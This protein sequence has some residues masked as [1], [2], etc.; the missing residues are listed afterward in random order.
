MDTK[1]LELLLETIQC[2]SM[3]RAAE[4]L[5]YT[6]SG[7]V[8]MLNSLE[9]ELSL[10]LLV[11]NYRGVS[12]T[13]NGK[14]L[15]PYIR[16]LVDSANRLEKQISVLIEQNRRVLYIGA[17]PAVARHLIPAISHKFMKSNPNVNIHIHVGMEELSEWVERE[18]IELAIC[19]HSITNNNEW[20]PV[21]KD[22]VYVAVPKEADFSLPSEQHTSVSLDELVDCPVLLTSHNPKSPGSGKLAQWV[23][24]SNRSQHLTIKAPDGSVQLSMVAKGLGITFLSSLYRYECPETVRMYPLDPPLY[25]NLG[26]IIK[27]KKFLSPLAKEFI[28]F[29]K[30]YLNGSEMIGK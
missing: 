6:Q 23:T 13:P 17:Y 22:E 12:F 5:N 21:V 9:Q 3:K 24:S 30:D 14:E 28:T 29:F 4:K 2:G 19:E 27:S 18:N 15:E 26:C 8:Y 7:L 1:K 25:R 16:E 20:I 10:P 11:R